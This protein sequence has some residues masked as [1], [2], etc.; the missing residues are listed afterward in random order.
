MLPPCRAHRDHVPVG[1][2]VFVEGEEESGS[3]SLPAILAKHGDR[4][5]A[6][7]I[8]IADSTNWAIGAPALTT[9]LRGGVRAVVRVQT[10]DHSVHSGMFGGAAPDAVTALVRLLA[11]LHDDEGNV[12]VQGL[13]E[14]VA[15]ELDYDEARFR[16]ESGLLTASSS[17]APA[18]SCPDCGPNR[19][20]RR[21]ASMRRRWRRPPT[22]SRHGPRPRSPCGSRPTQD[23]Q[24]AFE[25]LR[26]HLEEHAPWGAQGC[27]W[28]R[29]AV[30]AAA[31]ADGPIYDQ[32]RASF[33]D[34]WDVDPVDMGVGGSIRSSRTSRRFPEAAILVTG[35]EDRTAGRM[36]RTSR[37]TSGSSPGCARQRR[38]SWRL[39]APWGLRKSQI[40][41]PQWTWSTVCVRFGSTVRVRCPFEGVHR[42]V[43][44]MRG[45]REA[46]VESRA[47]APARPVG[48]Y[49]KSLRAAAGLHRASV[50]DGGAS[51]GS[52]R[53]GRHRAPSAGPSRKVKLVALV[54]VPLLLLT[55]GAYS[56]LQARGVDRCARRCGDERALTIT[57]SPSLAPVLTKAAAAF[58]EDGLVG[59]WAV[60]HDDHRRSAEP[61]VFADALRASL[62]AGGGANA[63]TAWVPDAASGVRFSAAARASTALPRSFPVVAVSP[64]VIAAPRAMAEA[65]GWPETQPS[66][67]ERSISP[68]TPRAGAPRGI[69]SGDGYASAGRTRFAT[70]RA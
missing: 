50:R 67:T 55:L 32:A 46:A 38:S 23:P 3:P 39:G 45:T 60:H 12:A 41:C 8:V 11:T 51:R 61:N 2:T 69:R 13:D 64:A 14:G 6:D 1:V 58:D 7:A 9:T 5:A 28:R 22:L 70:Q 31:Q 18:R 63:P 35:V 52:L 20:S 40:P 19:P 59:R 24:K 42:Q 27:P 29:R 15:A 37:S 30:L 66:W 47:W 10:L 68:R 33:R 44:M 4:L 25:L 57:A 54:L 43:A 62:E 36:A 48:P 53:G 34:A 56:D 49:E 65:M 16:A 21:S 26:A 17:S